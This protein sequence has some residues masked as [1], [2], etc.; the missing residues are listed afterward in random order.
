MKNIAFLLLCFLAAGCS[1]APV[2]EKQASFDEPVYRKRPGYHFQ[3]VMP[4]YY[5]RIT[6]TEAEY[7]ILPQYVQASYEKINNQE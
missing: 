4:M 1:T 2:W 5:E 6:I 7:R 3:M